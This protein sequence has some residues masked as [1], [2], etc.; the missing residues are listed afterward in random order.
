MVIKWLFGDKCARCEE[1]RTKGTFEGLPTCEKCEAQI[2][3]EREETR[4]CPLDGAEMSKEIVLNVVIDRCPSC[5]GVWLD[6]GELEL[7]NKGIEEGGG[8]DFASGFVVGMLVG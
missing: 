8:G 7:V 4:R 6:G 1:Q 2:R 3:A 5:S